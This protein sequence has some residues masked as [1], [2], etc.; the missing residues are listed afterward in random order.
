MFFGFFQ[1][2]GG[3]WQFAFMS[4]D[5]KNLEGIREGR[6]ECHVVLAEQFSS[7]VL[8]WQTI[9]GTRREN[10]LTR[11]LVGGEDPR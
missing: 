6:P 9:S 4:S 10:L 1:C 7:L 2:L 5:C 11:I 8:K 3:F